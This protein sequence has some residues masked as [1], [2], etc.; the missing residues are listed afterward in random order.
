MS[1][2]KSKAFLIFCLAFI[3]GV[4]LGR[5]INHFIM[6][7][8][9]MF[10]IGLIT[11][12]WK[13]KLAVVIGLAGVVA[14]LGSLRFQA[15]YHQNDLAP[16][17]GLE[18]LAS[19]LIM[20]EP[21]VRTDKVYLTLGQIIIGDR[22][23]TSKVLA[24]VPLFPEYQYGQKVVFSAKLE[25]PKEFPDFNY[26]NYL[27]RFGIDAVAYYPKV[28]SADG[29]SGNP[30]KYYILK[31]KQRFVENL[32]H[33]LPEPQASF[34]GGLLLGAKRAIPQTLLDQFSATGTS[35]IVA[36]SGYNISI[37]AAGIGWLLQWLGLRKRISFALS[38][39]AIIAFVFM[40][41]ASASVIRA[42]VMGV[43]L[44]IALNIGRLYAI[45]NALV[46]SAA[47]MLAFNPQILHFDIGFQLSFAAVLGL[48][49]FSPLI[50]PYFLWMPKLLRNYLLATL[51][52]QIFTLPILLYYFGSLSIVAVPVNLLVMLAVPVAMLFGFLAGFVGFVG[53]KLA[54]PLMAISWLLLTYILKVVGLFA[55]IP[56]ASLGLNINIY[57]VLV[58]YL[59]L[60]GIFVW[61]YKLW[62]LRPKT[63][64]NI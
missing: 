35:H 22:E 36:V 46:F 61:Y 28:E 26:K 41:G 60:A 32:N 14:L 56:Y 27:S 50:E 21:D 5:F 11:I 57:S 40:T 45:T 9:A 38:V 64:S 2:S 16:F 52:A 54:W 15:T 33:L 42:G 23:L 30:I 25:E 47:V 55:S 1:L 4:F 19:S 51:A 13:N 63:S 24:T 12:G 37:I 8:A 17:Y 39:I 7:F 20:E 53:L 59:I 18:V 62:T 10:F 43:L 49:Y 34:M 3:L 58:Y 44:L 31:F 29:N 48:I 6:A